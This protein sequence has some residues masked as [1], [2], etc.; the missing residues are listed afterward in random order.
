MRW[1]TER[2][3]RKRNIGGERVPRFIGR[4]SSI[5][6][7]FSFYRRILWFVFLYSAGK[8]GGGGE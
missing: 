5:K 3:K 2:G 6:E 1:I 7:V 4:Y 8:G